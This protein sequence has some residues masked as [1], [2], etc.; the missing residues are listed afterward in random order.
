M[1]CWT[2]SVPRARVLS[3]SDAARFFGGESARRR[4]DAKRTEQKK[5]N[6]NNRDKKGKEK[7]ENRKG[8]ETRQRGFGWGQ[9]GLGGVPQGGGP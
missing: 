4:E 6:D 7:K 2:C 8:E 3:V 9:R 5:G 1:S